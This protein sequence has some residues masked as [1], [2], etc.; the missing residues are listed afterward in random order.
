MV[1]KFDVRRSRSLLEVK[2]ISISISIFFIFT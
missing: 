2:L 1:L